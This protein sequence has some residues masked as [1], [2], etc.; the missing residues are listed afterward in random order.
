M[1]FLK[2]IIALACISAF[3]TQAM[4]GSKEPKELLAAHAAKSSLLTADEV[5]RIQNH[6]YSRHKWQ[7]N[8]LGPDFEEMAHGNGDLEK[9][10]RAIYQSR[11]YSSAMLAL[12]GLC[13]KWGLDTSK[14]T[15]E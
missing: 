13:K 14:L 4:Q 9:D 7:M 3:N 5:A 2:N 11:G 10:L 6:M 8:L 15:D 1:N 12:H